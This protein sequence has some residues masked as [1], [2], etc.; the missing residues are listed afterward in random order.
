MT[1]HYDVKGSWSIS[2]PL[3]RP[4]GGTLGFPSCKVFPFRWDILATFL[5]LSKRL[6]VLGCLD[7]ICS[8]IQNHLALYERL[9]NRGIFRPV[10]HPK[11]LANDHGTQLDLATTR[12]SPGAWVHGS[13]THSQHSLP[14]SWSK[15]QELHSK[16]RWRPRVIS[17]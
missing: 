17:M 1:D 14:A 16:L 6:L 13:L 12:V 7:G 4:Q 8:F 15:V 9:V 11:M 10:W 2:N 5:S 3:I